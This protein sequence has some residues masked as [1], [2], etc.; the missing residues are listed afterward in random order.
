MSVTASK[1]LAR[2][3]RGGELGVL[4]LAQL[5]LGMS[6][7]WF[8]LPLPVA[9]AHNGTGALL[10]LSMV[11]LNHALRPRKQGRARSS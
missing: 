1:M 9:T 5:A 10:L 3:W 7:L 8:D 2:D 11:L 4:L 6:N